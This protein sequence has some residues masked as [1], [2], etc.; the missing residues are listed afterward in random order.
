[1]EGLWAPSV[2]LLSCLLLPS[3]SGSQLSPSPDQ[4]LQTDPKE[5]PPQHHAA[6][7][8]QE[9]K[10][11]S[12]QEGLL[13]PRPRCVRC[14]EPA[15]QRFSYT[16]YQPLPQINM[17]ILKGEKGDRGERGMQGKFGKT[18]VAGSRGHAGP[19]GQKGS[20]GAPGERCKSHY[21]AFSVGRKKPLHSND[22]YQTLIFDTQFVNL[23]EHFNMFTGKFYCYVPGIYYFSLNVH[24][25]NQKETYLH[26]MRNGA[27]V[28][29]LY[30]Q[31]SDRSIMQSQSV[32]LEL[33]EQ[34]EV[35]VRLY[36]GERENAIFSDEYDTYITFSG[37]LIKYSGDP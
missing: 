13:P 3:S 35:W 8:I 34:D 24:T 14:C 22:Y 20:M 36:K 7:A 27:E 19:K 29:I 10:A 1:M 4:R 28:V 2:L 12:A 31:V 32:M 37:H 33:Q 6:R 18:G 15:D 21:A 11:G 16:Q 17:T 5:T 9:Q 30:A 26:I 23:Y 25:W